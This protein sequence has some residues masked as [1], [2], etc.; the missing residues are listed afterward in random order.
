MR[1]QVAGLALGFVAACGGAL[2][3][4]VHKSDFIPDGS[5]THF[6][7]FESVPFDVAGSDVANTSYSEGGIT[8]TQVQGDVA[9]N[10]LAWGAEGARAWSSNG[11]DRGYTAITLTGGEN[12][13]SI[14]FL[15][16]DMFT[17]TNDLTEVAYELRL[18]G[19]QVVGGTFS[20]VILG[21]PGYLGFSGG[22]FD[23]VR[24]IAGPR[25]PFPD[26]DEI[27]GGL[28]QGA[29]VDSI[30][31][32]G[33]AVAAVPEP[34]GLGLLGLALAIAVGRRIRERSRMQVAA[35]A[36]GFVAASGGASAA[37]VHTSDFIADGSR[38]H[39]NGFESV[40]FVGEADAA[41]ATAY[42]EGGI[43]VTQVQGDVTTKLLGWGAE[44]S[45]D[46][47]SNG[48]DFG[49]IAI[50]LTGGGNFDATGFLVGDGYPPDFGATQI[51]YDL[52]LAGAQVLFGTLVANEPQYLGF[53]G[54][55][56]DEI[57]IIAGQPFFANGS[58]E[59]A[60]GLF[61]AAA[62]D[63]IET[64]GGVAPVP[65]PAGLALFGVALVMAMGSRIR[66]RS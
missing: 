20:R 57:R 7:G 66:A 22:G 29:V 17:I 42:S 53:S 32:I 1:M 59:I 30:E 13:D 12:F 26:F 31:T 28:F 25:F 39:F 18:D 43:T 16:A 8:V 50:T 9:T 51:A 19:V 54:G 49:Y 62:I 55:G 37:T 3:A 33:D 56:F 63:S 4:T 48:G 38:T 52:R 15:V 14:G 21:E 27:N 61:Q 23:E 10:Y 5:R 40:P 2:A 6:N 34:T 64:A 35:L 46:W 36:L 44:G 11:G 41:Y 24:I 45:H 60:G 58:S 47:Y 65:E